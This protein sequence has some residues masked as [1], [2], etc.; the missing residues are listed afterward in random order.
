MMGMLVL[1]HLA[2]GSKLVDLFR[3]DLPKRWVLVG[4]VLPDLI[5]KPLYY[6]LAWSTGR[7]G[8][9]LG[10]ISG[11]RSFGHSGLLLLLIAGWGLGRGSVRALALTAGLLTHLALD[12]AGDPLELFD[13]SATV[14]AVL[15]PF[16]G[17]E[18]WAQP[19]TR[20]L[21]QHLASRSSQ[22]YILVTEA[23]GGALLAWDGIAYW[24]DRNK[25]TGPALRRPES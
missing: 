11:T 3:L 12:L 19:P 6:A 22:T 7:G 20:T 13:R 18:F 1:G 24:R 9:E 15:F 21:V 25:A 14:R 16:L 5:D 23:I 2:I 17:F 10:L 8:A 4:A